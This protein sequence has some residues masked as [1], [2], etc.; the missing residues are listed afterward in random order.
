MSE[1]ESPQVRL[2]FRNQID[3]VA[4]LWRRA[5]EPQTALTDSEPRRQ[6]QLL[7]SVLLT[8]S[9]FIIIFLPL[10]Y[11]SQGSSAELG[12][13]LAVA[14][15]SGLVLFALAQ[16]SRRG[17]ARLVAVLA[18]LFGSIAI[19]FTAATVEQAGVNTLYYL[20]VL[21]LFASL[22][23]SALVTMCVYG[24]YLIGMLLL[25]LVGPNITFQRIVHGPLS[26][27]T[28]MTVSILV[29]TYLRNQ[30]DALRKQRLLESEARYRMLFSG[31]ND[32]IFVHDV[33]ANLLDVNSAACERL[34]YTRQELLSMKLTDL[35]APYYAHHFHEQL[36]AHLTE[37]GPDHIDGVHFTKDGRQIFVDINSER[38]RLE[39]Q[40][41]ELNVEK[42]KTRVMTEFITAA[43]HDFRTPLSVINTSLYLLGKSSNPQHQA[44]HI[45]KLGQQSAAIERLVD[46]LL[47]MARLDSAEPFSFDSVN[48]NSLLREIETQK[49]PACEEKSL[50]ASYELDPLLPLI[51]AD[52]QWLHLALLKLI[53]NAIAFTPENRLFSVQTRPDGDSVV[54][55]VSDTGVG[56]PEKDLAHIFDRLYRGQEY[57]PVGG[58]GLGLTIANRVVERHHGRIDVESALDVGS[59]FQVTLPRK[60]PVAPCE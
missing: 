29:F 49:R 8:L 15:A 28:L 11:L 40:A 10:R 20:V 16:V 21:I 41:L 24:I 46:G 50:G 33:D 6:A 4:T 22:F 43:S 27:I 54:V 51:E 39:R 19:F 45:E 52:S 34:G 57:R 36:A 3:M 38:R 26:F 17:H 42:E 58:Q 53:E 18:I 1:F 32:A 44:Y 5:T 35:S 2:F 55:T 14:V 56:I 13:R 23:F 12:L 37:G 30:L 7:S 60:Q 48:L 25:P 31:I 47:T 9:L 59:T